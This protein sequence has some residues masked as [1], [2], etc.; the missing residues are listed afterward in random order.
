MPL[1]LAQV[2]NPV[3]KQYKFCAAYFNQSVSHDIGARIEAED[4][5]FLYNF[6][7]GHKIGSI[8]E[9]FE[10][11]A[12]LYLLVLL[13][14]SYGV[15]LLAMWRAWRNPRA[16]MPGQHDTAPFITVVV[17]ARNEAK[18]IGALLEDLSRQNYTAYEV[19]M[20]DDHSEDN[21][22]AIAECMAAKYTSF[23][24]LRN[25]YSGKKQALT[26]GVKHAKGS[27][28]VATDADCRVPPQW[29]SSVAVYFQQPHVKMVFGGVR[30]QQRNFFHDLQ[31][32]E[33][34][35]LI[36]SG[37]ATA[38]MGYP[39]LCN[40]ANIAYR[41]D[42]FQEVNGYTGNTQVPSGDDEFLMRKINALYP[43]GIY[44]M[45][46]IQ[47]VVTTQ[48]NETAGQFIQQRL[49]WAGK[50]RYNTSAYTMLLAIYIFLI[51]VMTVLCWG[52]LFYR[53]ERLQVAALSFLLVKT[54]LEFLFLRSVCRFLGCRWNSLAFMTLQVI[55][56]LYVMGIGLF[57]H[58][59]PQRWKGR[60]L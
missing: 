1:V 52:L 22:V 57:A 43:D 15:G 13:G 46:D 23:Q 17:A 29:L 2:N 50:W 45:R 53:D 12:M 54:G 25:T 47:S 14:C 60:P 41:R 59:I 9:F 18:N 44:F 10:I 4:N 39:T 56:P 36:G 33:F 55:Y 49:R 40:G 48:P 42:V 26:E 21:T 16:V 27:I 3:L 35:S 24:V 58:F 34:S 28:I 6:S 20:V 32:I 19:I 38:G 5:F 31:A 7:H 8:R 30:M 51:Q 11:A 37:A